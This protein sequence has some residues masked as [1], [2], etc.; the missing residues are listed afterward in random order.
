[1]MLLDR[2][3]PAVLD[4]SLIPLFPGGWLHFPSV[5]PI[6]RPRIPAFAEQRSTLAVFRSP[7]S[8]AIFIRSSTFRKLSEKLARKSQAVGGRLSVS[9]I[10]KVAS[11]LSAL[12]L[13]NDFHTF[14]VLVC[15]LRWKLMS[16]GSN[17][18]CLFNWAS[19]RRPEVF[20][21]WRSFVR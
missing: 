13:K 19:P 18:R 8:V 1:M 4:L 2:A 20:N 17:L 3:R 10:K 12:F 16:C 21:G 14:G 6:L 5:S 15:G 9:F 7:S 11:S